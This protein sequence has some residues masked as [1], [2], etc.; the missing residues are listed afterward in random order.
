[1]CFL[2]LWLY[3]Q[4]KA[5]QVAYG[6]GCLPYYKAQQN[7]EDCVIGYNY[8]FPLSDS[9]WAW[10]FEGNVFLTICFYCD[11]WPGIAAMFFL[12]LA[13][14]RRGCSEFFIGIGVALQGLTSEWVKRATQCTT[15]KHYDHPICQVWTRPATSCLD[16]C[17]MFS[18]HT[19]VAYFYLGW[20]LA[21][22]HAWHKAKND[23]TYA[24]GQM[25]SELQPLLMPQL[26][27]KQQLDPITR[28]LRSIK[29]PDS[30]IN[31]SEVVIA[32]FLSLQGFVVWI[33]GDHS[34]FQVSIGALV[35]LVQGWLWFQYIVT[36]ERVKGL[37]KTPVGRFLGFYDNYCFSSRYT[38]EFEL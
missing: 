35:G 28:F 12:S 14:L 1:M 3:L 7:S 21:Y 32:T 33:V 36:P 31:F 29:I 23:Y 5:F 20:G 38:K 37:C 8:H 16:D 25:E 6:T 9:T 26:S 30:L 13:L 11:M 2:A 18:G 4:S 24:L 27:K 17:G 34:A 10:H 22:I 15:L 19:C